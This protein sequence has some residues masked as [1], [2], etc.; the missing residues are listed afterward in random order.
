MKSSN[1]IEESSIIEPRVIKNK[2]Q[3]KM[4]E[5]VKKHHSYE[6]AD[7][8]A[9]SVKPE[10]LANHRKSVRSLSVSMPYSDDYEF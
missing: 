8:L 7:F 9:M 4:H 3:V 1:S 2:N 5:K 10:L 6:P